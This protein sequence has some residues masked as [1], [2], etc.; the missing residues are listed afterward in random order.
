LNSAKQLDEE[1]KEPRGTERKDEREIFHNRDFPQMIERG[2]AAKKVKPQSSPSTQ[3][4]V[5]NIYG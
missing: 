3:R 5:R 1:G 2:A 4:N